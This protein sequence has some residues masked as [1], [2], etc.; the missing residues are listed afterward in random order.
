MR[1]YVKNLRVYWR[2]GVNPFAFFSLVFVDCFRVLSYNKGSSQRAYIKSR[3]VLGVAK[4]I[5][6]TIKGK[7]LHDTSLAVFKEVEYA[8]WKTP[9][10]HE[11]EY[12]GFARLEEDD[13]LA[14][15]IPVGSLS[16]VQKFMDRHHGGVQLVPRNIPPELKDMRYLKRMFSEGTKDTIAKQ[17]SPVFVKDVDTVKG[18]AGVIDVNTDLPSGNLFVTEALDVVSEWRIFVKGG[19]IAGAKNYAGSF[20][21]VPD[22]EFIKDCIDVYTSA[23]SG[24]TLDVM[25]DSRGETSVI[26]VHDFVSV[27]LYGFTHASLPQMIVRGFRDMLAYSM[28]NAKPQNQNS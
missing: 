16:F 14:G 2:R 15:G 26:E 8:N 22:V 21:L 17:D 24:Y 13:T 4:F 11:I 20:F 7:V 3:G 25:I 19:Q 9:G 12:A 1:Q 28:S 27:G 23:P 6:Q 18:Y 10:T 5:L